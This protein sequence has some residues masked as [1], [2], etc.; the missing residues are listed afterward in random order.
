MSQGAILETKS[1]PAG[2]FLTGWREPR[3]GHP[4]P[5]AAVEEELPEH[6]RAALIDRAGGQVDD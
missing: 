5:W 6:A 4:F 2:D 1:D 3:P